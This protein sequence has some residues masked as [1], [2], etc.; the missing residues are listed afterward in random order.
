[1][2][3]LDALKARMNSLENRIGAA[4]ERLALHSALHIDH[5]AT[6]DELTERYVHLQQQLNKETASLESEGVHVDSF[7]KTVLEWINGL[8]LAH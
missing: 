6:L 1:M 5:A 2:A 7:E 4:R 3:D 8:T